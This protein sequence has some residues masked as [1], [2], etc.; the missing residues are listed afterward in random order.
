MVKKNPKLRKNMLVAFQK[1][2]FYC[3]N[4]SFKNTDWHE[5]IRISRLSNCYWSI[6][7][8][9]KAD[10]SCT[11]RSAHLGT[12]CRAIFHLSL[13]RR[14]SFR[15]DRLAHCCPIWYKLWQSH[16]SKQRLSWPW[17]QWSQSKLL[18]QIQTLGWK[19]RKKFRLIFCINTAAEVAEDTTLLDTYWGSE[20]VRHKIWNLGTQDLSSSNTSF[21]K[22][23]NYDLIL[24]HWEDQ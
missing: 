7:N 3:K 19:G 20:I 9:Y 5:A 23:Y 2:G 11:H 1:K 14:H 21:Q 12:G 24:P 22:N 17:D 4:F 10:V 15:A 18:N 13:R 16:Q 6:S 8:C